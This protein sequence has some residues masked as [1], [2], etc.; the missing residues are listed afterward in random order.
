MNL[1]CFQCLDHILT[2]NFRAQEPVDP[3][4]IKGNLH[5]FCGAVVHFNELC[6]RFAGTQQFYQFHC[7]FQCTRAA[8]RIQSLFIACR[9][10]GTHAQLLGSPANLYRFE[11]SRL[12]DNGIGVVHNAAVFAAHDTGNGNGLFCIG[13][14]Q[15]FRRKLPFLSVQRGNGFAVLGIA[16]NDLAVLDIPLVERVHR[17]TIFQHDIVGDVHQIIDRTHAAGTKPFPHPAGRRTDLDILHHAGNVPRTECS[18][19]NRHRQAVAKLVCG[20]VEF[21]CFQVHGLAES[22]GSFSCQ[23]NHRQAVRTV[24]GDLEFDRS[25]VQTD[26]LMNVL[27]HRAVLLDEENAVFNGI[28]E[29]MLGQAKFAQRAQHAVALYAAELA[30]FDADTAGQFCTDHCHRHQCTLYDILG[31]GHDLDR[32]VAADI[33]LTHL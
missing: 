3:I 24:G 21:R 16:D 5:R 15:H 7:P 2:G 1:Q 22:H 23:T 4:R 18:I 33:D 30:L 6:H 13:N 12:K 11:I 32:R 8:V 19:F 17:L 27:S 10:I 28:G 31:T 25:I 9:S 20:A 14:D 29:V 26:C